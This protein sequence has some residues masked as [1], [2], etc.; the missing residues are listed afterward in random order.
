MR[1]YLLLLR[2]LSTSILMTLLVSAAYSQTVS[3]VCN[4]ANTSMTVTMSF[5]SSPD[6]SGVSAFNATWVISGNDVIFTIPDKYQYFEIQNINPFFVSLNPSSPELSDCILNLEVSG[7]QSFCLSNDTY[8]AS[9]VATGD[10]IVSYTWNVVGAATPASNTGSS[11]FMNWLGT[12]AGT[13]FVEVTSTNTS[14]CTET[15]SHPVYIIDQQPFAVACNGH[16]NLTMDESCSLGLITP[17]M[18][19][20]D[21]QYANDAY[22]INLYDE[23]DDLITTTIGDS[24]IGQTLTVE[25][26][27][28]CGGNSCWGLAT[29]EDKTIPP[30]VCGGPYSVDCDQ[31][32]STLG[33][34]T[35]VGVPT[36]N[37]DGTWN[38]P[39]YDNCGDATL[40]YMDI[41]SLTAC[42]DPL[43]SSIITRT[44]T[45]RDDNGSATSCVTTINVNRAD[46]NDVTFPAH[47]DP[48]FGTN[49]LEPKPCG[50]W[51][52]LDNGNPD[53]SST[54]VPTGAFCLDIEVGYYDTKFAGCNDNNFKIL[55]RWTIE[56]V[57]TGQKI[58]Y[59]QNIL[60]A[61]MEIPITICPAD[62]GAPPG[63][64]YD[65]VSYI[66]TNNSYNCSADWKVVPPVVNNECTGTYT[67]YVEYLLADEDGNPPAFADYISTNV[68]GT[69]PNFTIQDLPLGNTWIRYTVV[70][71][72]GQE[73]TCF[74][75]V[76]VYDNSE[77]HAV[78]DLQS[79][80]ALNSE[81]EAYAHPETFD[82][83]SFSC[84]EVTLRIRRVNPGQCGS[85]QTSFT[86]AIKF[87]CNDANS[88]V[89]IELEATSLNGQKSYCTVEA[90]IQDFT[91]SSF[92]APGNISRPFN[93]G[94][95][96]N[97]NSSSTLNGLYGAPS[98]TQNLCS[99]AS[100]SEI[101]PAVLNV[102]E[103]GDGTLTRRWQ[104]TNAQGSSSTHTQTVTLTLNNPFNGNIN[105]PN[106]I[107]LN[108]CKTI[109]ILPDDIPSSAA[110]RPSWNANSCSNTVAIYEDLPFY[111]V[112]EVCTKIL[113]TWTVIDWCQANS[114]PGSGIWEYTQIIK[115]NDDVAPQINTGCNL[116]SVLVGE[117]TDC[118][119]IV[120]LSAT[121]TDNCDD[122]L[123]W[124][125]TLN[126]S[127][128]S[129][130]TSDGTAS[131][132][133]LDLDAGNYTICWSVTDGC[134]NVDS[135]C[136]SFSIRDTKSPTAACITTLTTVIS[137]SN[138][139]TLI[140][141]SDFDAS[142]SDACTDQNQLRF[143][144][145]TN[146]SDTSRGFDCGDLA[147]GIVDTVE[148]EMYVFDQAGNYD[149]CPAMLILQ[150]NSDYCTDVVT[151]SN[152]IN[153]AGYVMTDDQQMVDEVMISMNSN[154]DVF[155]GM[156]Y[157]AE[158]GEFAFEDLVMYN[159]YSI[160]AERN[161]GFKEGVS[162]IDLL[163]I[164]KHILGIQ[165]LDSPYKVIAADA[166]NS[167]TISAIDL[168]ELRKLI[169]GIYDELPNNKSWRFVNAAAPFADPLS[170][171]PFVEKIGYNDLETD[172]DNA[173]FVAV[174][175]GDVNN[176]IE[177]ANANS[178]ATS[179][180]SPQQTI[181]LEV[182]NEQG[183]LKLVADEDVELYGFQ[184]TLSYPQAVEVLT[185]LRSDLPNFNSSNYSVFD[186]GSITVSYHNVTE[187][188]LLKGETILELEL[189]EDATVN[190]LELHSGLLKAEMYVADNY[191]IETKGIELRNAEQH[192]FVLH[193]NVPNPF[194]EST[195]IAF[196]IPKTSNVNLTIYD[197]TGR[198]IYE[199]SGTFEK[200][201]NQFKID[202]STFTTT[203]I[204][205]YQL[206]SY[207]HTA[208]KKMILFK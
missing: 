4:G 150:D 200:G 84:S 126:G 171:F 87:C 79:N 196:E 51:A 25:V 26:V 93:C 183:N 23:N 15:V 52:Q 115:I 104:Y 68:T 69:Y 91:Q 73:G 186:N 100:F 22:S 142:S 185:E 14:G 56:D 120:D 208:T 148:V 194:N 1:K 60:V 143:A 175:I 41:A 72:C 201:Y 189:Q 123:S 164:Q 86:D 180:R 140:W 54:G 85:S 116:P 151:S 108:G 74:T 110:R 145:S 198:I 177:L 121:A 29:I 184:F 113:R 152:R 149:S 105:W 30:L 138:G 77:P 65:V 11:L 96:L 153:L 88:T 125:A 57:C 76:L 89:L 172:V 20:E 48:A 197:A 141:A 199:K 204:L 37:G 193:Q 182:V 161:Y 165:L 135:C 159:D 127:P 195:L 130:Q 178:T 97:L 55:R 36:D 28:I 6:P 166:N 83:G 144:F 99:N 192:G 160:E 170:P 90:Y 10:N 207:T 71:Q 33:F 16:V 53:P 2:S 62:A 80:I 118:G 47:W 101:L 202:A 134:G 95:N 174:K 128:L 109:S 129:I 12:P 156:T 191:T 168:L 163:L 39:G 59:V 58:E 45:I 44:W 181:G 112:E 158:N 27:T 67:W 9:Y 5:A 49:A 162:T 190:N 82:D 21:M 173:E 131:A 117:E 188:N 32:T 124:T 133:N 70:D 43:Y 119:A 98:L 102:D 42:T 147:N 205:Y 17:D 8:V 38:V 7:K 35:N 107:T 206:D 18:F 66:P 187:L 146:I 179:T 94:T 106:D 31:I 167:E 132:S 75:E 40:S 64:L 111:F 81:G 24:Y 50:T 103:C 122:G 154:D 61:D 78:C 46:I 34:P 155:N 169:L 203:G 92:S 136:E 114:T 157:M 19:L 63:L 139:E 13:Y 176:S 3:C 137:N